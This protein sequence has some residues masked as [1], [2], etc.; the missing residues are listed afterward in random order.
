M[1]GLGAGACETERQFILTRR[2]RGGT[3]PAAGTECQGTGH[4]SRILRDTGALLSVLKAHLVEAGTG[5]PR[6]NI[7][8]K[9]S[10][11]QFQEGVHQSTHTV[12]GANGDNVGFA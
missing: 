2:K 6:A 8:H 3:W 12:A 1:Q 11:D 5:F 10:T 4:V 9:G 7:N